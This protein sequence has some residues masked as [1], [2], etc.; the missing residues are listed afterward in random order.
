VLEHLTDPKALL[1]E[2]AAYAAKHSSLVFIA[3]PWATH[4]PAW[5]NI[6]EPNPSSP[7]NPFFLA[8]VHINHFSQLG[9]KELAKNVGAKMIDLHPPGTWNGFWMRF[10]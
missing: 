1:A 6:L 5:G 10:S 4:K 2:I 7:S 9:L 3:V 8:D